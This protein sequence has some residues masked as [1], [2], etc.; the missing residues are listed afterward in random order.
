[1]T[2]TRRPT[3]R[4][5]TCQRSGD[6]CLNVDLTMTVSEG[7]AFQAA[8][9]RP[10]LFDTSH[11]A[12]GWLRLKR[13]GACPAL[14]READGSATCTVWDSRPYQCRRFMCGR[15]DPSTEA[16]EIGG[17][18]GCKNLSDRVTQSLDFAEYYRSNQRRAQREWAEPHGWHK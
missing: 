13:D 8:A 7:A 1:V 3:V 9:D 2:D 5:W 12:Q 14:K 4:K 18:M 10:I 17:P 16:Y 11:A 15:P 6:C